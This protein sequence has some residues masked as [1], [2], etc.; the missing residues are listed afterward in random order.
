MHRGTAASYVRIGWR[1]LKLA[2]LWQDS[3]RR[4]W[5]SSQ[6]QDVKSAL[7][8]AADNLRGQEILGVQYLIGVAEARFGLGVVAEVVHRHLERDS[9]RRHSIVGGYAT[10]H[11]KCSS[12]GE[13]RELLGAAR[14]LTESMQEEPQ[15]VLFLL[16][17]IARRYGK[18]VLKR[19]EDV[20]ELAWLTESLHQIQSVCQWLH[21]VV[22][23]ISGDLLNLKEH[24][25]IQD[26]FVVVGH[27]YPLVRDAVA[28]CLLS[29][30]PDCL[31]PLSQVCKN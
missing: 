17:Q 29:A 16:K 9:H 13:D 27:P 24:E 4:A 20:H 21:S 25:V 26:N 1:E 23:P 10:P 31:D 18:E 7:Q 12:D 15:L 14:E 2:V 19:L 3:Y 11:S 8:S 6:L 22:Q 5:T 28:R 30:D